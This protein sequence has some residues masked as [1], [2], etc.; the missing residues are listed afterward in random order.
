MMA[1][2]YNERLVL[3]R[4]SNS[5]SLIAVFS[6]LVMPSMD[7]ESNRTS[8]TILGK[9]GKISSLKLAFLEQFNMSSAKS[10]VSFLIC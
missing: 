6:D 3:E 5:K 8:Q 2:C 1:Q 10:I 7:G 9:S 4:N